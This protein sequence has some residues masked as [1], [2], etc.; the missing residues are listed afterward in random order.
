[1]SRRCTI[2]QKK[3]LY[4]N[5]VSHAHNTTRKRQLPNIQYKKVFVPE[6]KTFVRL[7]VAA[8]TLR[9]IDKLGLMPFLRKNKLTLSQI[10]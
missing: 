2:T 6:L 7:K 1:M 4:G 9:S 5:N 3:P 10:T 8:S